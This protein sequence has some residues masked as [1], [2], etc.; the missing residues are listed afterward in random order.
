MKAILLSIRP[1]HAL[2]I[3]NGDKTLELR[4]S[5]P[6]D[7]VGWV[8]VY[9]TKAKPFLM[10]AFDDTYYIH[11]MTEKYRMECDLNGKVV[12]RWW[13]DDYDE[14]QTKYRID[15]NQIERVIEQAYIGY[16][17]FDSYVGDKEVI[18]GWHIKKLEIFDK[19]M[20][21]R[22]FRKKDLSNVLAAPTDWPIIID[23]NIVKRP[24]QSYQRV[25]VKE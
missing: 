9:V 16:E 19:P 8:Y 10:H 14:V 24:P 6:K 17:G 1:E 11:D 13:H 25:Y 23:N 20:Q 5:V 4:K 12:A 18:Y 21:L 22:E 7:F 15:K 3:L 2:N